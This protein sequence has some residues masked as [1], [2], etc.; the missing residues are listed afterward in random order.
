MDGIT[1]EE[2]RQELI[3]GSLS[4]PDAE[5][6]AIIKDLTNRLSME[7][8]EV[9][10]IV[11]NAPEEMVEYLWGTREKQIT[12]ITQHD[13]RQYLNWSLGWKFTLI[14]KVFSELKRFVKNF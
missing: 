3:D 8:R 11:L 4:R 5:K 6:Q 9:I 7:A 2:I 1:L 10:S 13:L 12:K 14:A